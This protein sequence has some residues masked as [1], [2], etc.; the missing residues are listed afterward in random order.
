MNI[1]DFS[2]RNIS[3]NGNMYSVSSLTNNAQQN[4]EFE[5]HTHYDKFEIYY[6]LK[7]D[8]YFAFEGK[9]FDVQ[10][11]S[12]IIIA[13]GM[14]HRPIIKKACL[15]SR[16][17]LLFTKE[18]FTDFN[19][20]ELEL[21]KMLQEN[22]IIILSKDTVEKAHLN[23]LFCKT[24]E[25][26]SLHTKHGDF[27]AVISLF[28]LLIKI[29]EN[30]DMSATSNDALHNDTVLKIIRYINDN[31]NESLTYKELAKQ[32]FISEKSLYKFFKKETGFTLSSYINESRIVKAQ[33]VLNSGK[34]AKEAAIEAGFK[35]Y[36][37]FYRNFL[38]H[39]GITPLQYIKKISIK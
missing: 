6:F 13:T 3:S 28:S 16:K 12:M 31:L 36:T 30:I 22:K 21:Y 18:I 37:V 25:Y 1:P 5:I 38:K 8:L 11:G 24:E 34:S 17:R 39:T 32:F 27:C 4:N 19:A 9:R 26:L 15:Y 20:T 14:L 7:G 35:D 2:V 23:D 29:C 10:E 33:S